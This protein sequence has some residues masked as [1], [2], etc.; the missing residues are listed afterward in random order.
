[1]EQTV[2]F[3]DIDMVIT[4]KD[5]QITSE[6]VLILNQL[7]KHFQAKIVLISSRFLS[8]EAYYETDIAR[9]KATFL[10]QNHGIVRK[11]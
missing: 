9:N 7:L 8:Q 1:M 6:C 5:Y 11:D 3:L 2:I 4:D 10:L